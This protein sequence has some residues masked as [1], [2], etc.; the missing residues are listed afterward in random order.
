VSLADI[1]ASVFEAYK[2]HRAHV[3]MI[4][5]YGSCS[6]SILS[7]RA[8]LT[9]PFLPTALHYKTPNVQLTFS[10]TPAP[11]LCSQRQYSGYSWDVNWG[12]GDEYKKQ[13]GPMG[14]YQAAHTCK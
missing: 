12:D 14:P 4:G 2:K 10:H 5:D 11:P 7:P 9:F 13:Q 1:K 8:L 6:V 3:A